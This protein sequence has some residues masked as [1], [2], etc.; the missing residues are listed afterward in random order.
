MNFGLQMAKNMTGASATERT[1]M[2]LGI[3]THSSCYCEQTK[4][5]RLGQNTNLC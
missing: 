1:A 4:V 5:S 2:R 3:A